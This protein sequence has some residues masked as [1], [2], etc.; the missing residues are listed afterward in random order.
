MGKNESTVSHGME[1]V[2]KELTFMINVLVYLQS[3]SKMESYRLKLSSF[4]GCHLINIA[5]ELHIWVLKSKMGAWV[6][7][8]PSLSVLAFA[9]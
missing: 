1:I 9:Q 2:I 7:L 3:W 4:Q 8:K 6:T 5:L